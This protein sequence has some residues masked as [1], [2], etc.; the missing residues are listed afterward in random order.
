V[1]HVHVGAVFIS[2]EH[3]RPPTVWKR[4]WNDEISQFESEM[5]SFPT[6]LIRSPRI[7][8]RIFDHDTRACFFKEQ[9]LYVSGTASVFVETEIRT[10]LPYHMQVSTCSWWDWLWP[11]FTDCS[12]EARAAIA[13]SMTSSRYSY[14]VVLD[15]TVYAPYTISCPCFQPHLRVQ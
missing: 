3:C 9:R 1:I 5:S 13:F 2:A 7:I 12:S 8:S 6:G 10:P 11:L 4:R 14:G 15:N